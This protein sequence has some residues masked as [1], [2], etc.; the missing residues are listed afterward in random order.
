MKKKRLVDQF[1]DQII[2]T[3]R[4]DNSNVMTF[5]YMTDHIL[6]QFYES[7]KQEDIVSE[8][9][10]IIETVAKLINNSIKL[11]RTNSSI[12]PSSDIISSVEIILTYFPGILKAFQQ[13]LFV[14]KDIK[15]KVT[16]IG[17]AISQ[18]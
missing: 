14:G 15:I 8:K 17:Q 12:Y 13:H 4:D 16:S 10:R 9:Y 2:I 18:T 11:L 1:K 3:V 6:H 7:P 5:I